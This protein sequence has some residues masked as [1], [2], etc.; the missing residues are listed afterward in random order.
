LKEIMKKLS[1]WGTGEEAL[2]TA[3]SLGYDYLNKQQPEEETTQP[4]QAFG[5]P[6]D[7][8]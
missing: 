3:I 4:E 8:R 5:A 7:D 6:R 1:A 2:I